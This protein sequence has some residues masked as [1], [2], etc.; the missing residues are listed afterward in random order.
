MLTFQIFLEII[1]ILVD[2]GFAEL[3]SDTKRTYGFRASCRHGKTL[4]MGVRNSKAK[5]ADEEE[6]LVIFK[7]FTTAL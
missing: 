7:G 5:S 1:L 3:G 2:G 4:F 6:L